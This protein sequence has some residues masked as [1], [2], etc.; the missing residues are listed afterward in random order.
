MINT[1]IETIL[2][3]VVI[4]FILSVILSAVMEWALTWVNVRGH[5]LERGLRQMLNYGENMNLS[6]LVTTHPIIERTRQKDRRSPSYIDPK[7][8]SKVLIQILIKKFNDKSGDNDSYDPKYYT[9]ENIIN[10]IVKM[11]SSTVKK[12]LSLLIREEDGTIEKFEKEISGWY[13]AYNH[14]MSGWYKRLMKKY[15]FFWG[16]LF[17][18]AFNV[19]SIQIFGDVV[20]N[21]KFRQELVSLGDQISQQ[22][23]VDEAIKIINELEETSF[24]MSYGFIDDTIKNSSWQETPVTFSILKIIGWLLTAVALSFGS[25]FWFESIKK[26]INVRSTG[27]AT[28][29]PKDDE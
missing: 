21:A 12:E 5:M 18:V 2:S 16:I 7:L 25:Q 20:N 3:L 14:R 29:K 26:L 10:A 6:Y 19:D 13:T 22:E 28:S 9:K 15:L 23:N 4:Y 11:P 17:A 27:L 8:F 24:P 1:I